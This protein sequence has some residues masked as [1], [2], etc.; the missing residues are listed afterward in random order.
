VLVEA[1]KEVKTWQPQA[2]SPLSL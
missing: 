2:G 1:D